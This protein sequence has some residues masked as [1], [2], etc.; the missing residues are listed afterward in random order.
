MF[1][2]LNYF[3]TPFPNT[4]GYTGNSLPDLIFL[5]QSELLPFATVLQSIIAP[6]GITFTKL[7]LVSWIAVLFEF[8]FSTLFDPG[9]SWTSEC[10][11]LC[12][13]GLILIALST[14]VLCGTLGYF[15]SLAY[16]SW[17]NHFQE[18]Y[19]E[20]LQHW[21]ISTTSYLGINLKDGAP[22]VFCDADFLKMQK[23]TK[24][25]NNKPYKTTTTK[26]GFHITN[27]S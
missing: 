15:V 18:H 5:Y 24:K 26:N 22:K 12:Q 20:Q 7:I 23:E 10:K 13:L 27:T 6:S 11:G 14:Q 4:K 2:Q 3:T 8:S 21:S 16:I 19:E 25:P 1:K 9:C 17:Y